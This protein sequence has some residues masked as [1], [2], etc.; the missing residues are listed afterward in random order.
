MSPRKRREPPSPISPRRSPKRLRAPPTP[1]NHPEEAFS[2]TTPGSGPA[3]KYNSS[4][5]YYEIKAILDESDTKYLV[6]WADDL[7]SK[8]SYV[9]DW[10]STPVSLFRIHNDFLPFLTGK[11]F[12]SLCS[13][14]GLVTCR[15]A[16]I[17]TLQQP[18]KFLNAAAVKLWE[19]VKAT[20]TRARTQ[21]ESQSPPKTPVRPRNPRVLPPPSTRPQLRSSSAAQVYE[22]RDASE[23]QKRS[24]PAPQSQRSIQTVSPSVDISIFP[25]VAVQISQQSDLEKDS[26]LT[27]HSTSSAAQLPSSS[28]TI[29]NG[30]SRSTASWQP[31][32]PTIN[33]SSTPD[34]SLIPAGSTT[35]EWT[36]NPDQVSTYDPSVSSN[37][38]PTRASA[39]EN[40]AT[41]PDSQSL[42]RS[43][44][45]VAVSPKSTPQLPES[46]TTAI[47]N[48]AKTQHNSDSENI[49]P[50]VGTKSNTRISARG[51]KSWVV[52][53]SS[54][55]SQQSSRDSRPSRS[56]EPLG[57]RS[58]QSVPSS[59]IQI[60]ASAESLSR[61]GE[62]T[63]SGTQ[64]HITIPRTQVPSTQEV[65][66]SI[67]DESVTQATNS[68][69]QTNLPLAMDSRAPLDSTDAPI[70]KPA[71]PS[72]ENASGV[73]ESMAERL[74]R[75]FRE[76]SART[77]AL[78]TA[79]REERLRSRT[80]TPA[81]PS[82]IKRTN[83]E[84]A[85]RGV[86]MPRSPKAPSSPSLVRAA[87]SP[88]V[89][90]SPSALRSPLEV[91]GSNQNIP[92]SPRN[93]RSPS[94]I[95]ERLP[96]QP[97][98]GQ[99]YLPVEPSEVAK[100]VQASAQRSR[101]PPHALVADGPSSSQTTTSLPTTTLDVRSLGPM[102]YLLP[103]SMPPRTQKQY[104]ETYRFYLRRI[105]SFLQNGRPDDALRDDLNVLLDRVGKVTTHMDLDGGG[106]SSQEQV[107]ADQEASYAESC[108]EK[109]RFLGHLLEATQ[110]DILHIVIFAREGQLLDYIE[111]FLRS[112]KVNY[113]RPD[114]LAKSDPDASVGQSHISLLASRDDGSYSS[115]W[116]A[117]LVIAFDETFDAND[118]RVK[119][120]RVQETSA[121]EMS[122]VIRLVVYGSLEHINLC[123]STALE[124]IERMRRLIYCMLICEK[125]VG[126]L[127]TENLQSSLY[128]PSIYASQV[129]EFLHKG[130]NQSDWEVPSMPTLEISPAMDLDSATS[131]AMSETSDEFRLDSA[132]WFWPNPKP[133]KTKVNDVK[134][135]EK[136]SY[137]SFGVLPSP[138]LSNWI[139]SSHELLP[140]D[141]FKH[142]LT[143]MY[144]AGPRIWRLA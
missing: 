140:Y 122:P 120:F 76:V 100:N 130:S 38:S 35:R 89:P 138:M 107:D 14:L 132:A 63:V 99:S 12:C 144:Y 28:A 55:Q 96:Y 83:L 48:S 86:N 67:E 101:T 17:G 26:Y 21:K 134:A 70:Q 72:P 19:A 64:D 69:V 141:N 137:V 7:I 10:V 80:A 75:Q 102:E 85:T 61:K 59:S 117:D 88:K 81:I 60:P 52:D 53:D 124:P 109:F 123:I 68:P 49:Q 4:G 32:T 27:Y 93:M 51:V 82:P 131:E 42:P 136:R 11:D 142:F 44:N 114:S 23:P 13:Q 126:Q 18:K 5:P 97:Q 111:T 58:S 77:N 16:L 104:I 90:L 47:Q 127:G 79:E 6:D 22:G 74:D 45:H 36:P 106:P 50:L 33:P 95:P 143:V 105:Q 133:R 15:G 92:Q 9:P 121:L 98:G 39:S 29:S 34:P 20:G 135:G 73:P 24:A 65:I 8:Q 62:E 91:R 1:W 41:I 103:L 43:P 71:E 94:H 37:P 54:T 110:Q 112:K 139:E 129:V 3:S 118:L 25:D 56:K 57:D 66:I 115:S 128:S 78:L 40:G 30:N 84:I 2:T 31:E 87:L 116:K 119:G 125:V 46:A 113:T 108:S